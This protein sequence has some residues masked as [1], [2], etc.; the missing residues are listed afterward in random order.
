VIPLSKGGTDYISNIQPLCQSCNSKK[1][2][3]I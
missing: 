1:G 2:A 3:R